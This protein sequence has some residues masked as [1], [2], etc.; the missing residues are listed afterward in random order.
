MHHI[1]QKRT[2][3]I[4]EMTLKLDMSKTYD[5]VEW[6]RLKGIMQKLGINS[7]IMEIVLRCVRTVTYSVWING[8]PR[9]RSIPTRGL[10]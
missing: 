3:K 7:R 2:G 4:R 1:S 8:I 5:R 6:D 9:G 10:R